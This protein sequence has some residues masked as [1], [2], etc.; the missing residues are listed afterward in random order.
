MFMGTMTVAPGA[1]I[2]VTNKD[3]AAH[4]LTGSGFG[5]GNLNPGQTKTITAPMTPGSYA[6]TCDY[7]P[8]MHGTLI[9][10]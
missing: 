7:H 8:N 6:L 9:V 3:S 10:A 2:T 1:T 4:T 5:T